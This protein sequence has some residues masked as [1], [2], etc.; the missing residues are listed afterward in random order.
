MPTPRGDCSVR[1]PSW[2][3]ISIKS[4]LVAVR[5]ACL[6]FLSFEIAWHLNL[7]WPVRTQTARYNARQQ[8]L[9]YEIIQSGTIGFFHHP[10]SPPRHPA[11]CLCVICIIVPRARRVHGFVPSSLSRILQMVW[12]QTVV[13]SLF[14]PQTLG[15]RH[16]HVS[17]GVLAYQRSAGVMRLFFACAPNPNLRSNSNKSFDGYHLQNS[18]WTDRTSELLKGLRGVTM[19]KELVNWVAGQRTTLGELLIFHIFLEINSEKE[20]P[21]WVRG[22]VVIKQKMQRFLSSL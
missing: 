22:M 9:S 10:S 14:S 19:D 21:H 20:N 1:W 12:T 17:R 15:P 13:S 11:S 3:L 5:L 18:W 16:Y 7:R 6:Q 4:Q 8:I 2:Q